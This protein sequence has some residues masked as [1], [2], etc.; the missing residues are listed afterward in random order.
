MSNLV[1]SP[2][3]MDN[4]P[5][6]QK[7]DSTLTLIDA[8]KNA[9]VFYLQ[10]W[11]G[12]KLKDL[13][14][15]NILQSLILID[16]LTNDDRHVRANAAYVFAALGDSR[17]FGTLENILSD[18]SPRPR[19]QGVPDG[20]WTLQAQIASDRYY[21]AHVLGDLKDPRAVPILISLLGDKE[22]NAI[23]PWSLSQ[24]G[25][26]RAVQ[27]LVNAL[28]DKEPAMRVEAIY[29]LGDMH[30]TEALPRLRQLV[31]DKE[32][33]DFEDLISVGDAAR[34]TIPELEPHPDAIDRLAAGF[35][36]SDGLWMNGF[37]DFPIELPPSA[38]LDSVIARAF[39]ETEFDSGRVMDY[40]ILTNRNVVVLHPAGKY[41]MVLVKTNLGKKIVMAQYTKT[42]KGWWYRIYDAGD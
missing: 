11:V 22:V 1:A 3:A 7:L 20:N 5:Y 10:A 35:S 28:D 4:L 17:G 13:H 32:H 23:V 18:R 9:K 24:I 39:K 33:C 27:A 26:P 36:S 6:P 12:Y 30:D 38:T 2:V 37:W 31:N 21:A 42:G 14:D 41:T 29:A 34:G 8:F 40:Q 15:T 19:S 25:G 16:D